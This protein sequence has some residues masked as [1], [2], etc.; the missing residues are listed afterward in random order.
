MPNPVGAGLPTE[1]PTPP[2]A[3]EPNQA[4]RP[5]GEGL[6]QHKEGYR[7]GAEE[8][9]RAANAGRV[10]RRPMPRGALA[11]ADP[12]GNRP[13]N[14][15]AAGGSFAGLKFDPRDSFMPP[16]PVFAM[17][18]RFI[19]QA[20]NDDFTVLDLRGRN[21]MRLPDGERSIDF[22]DFFG[23]IPDTEDV[24]WFDPRA[25]YDAETDRFWLA[26]VGG[27]FFA[28]DESWLGL[29]VSVTD[30]PTGAWMVYGSRLD[31]D[32]NTQTARWGDFPD[33]GLRGDF[34]VATANQFDF[35][36]PYE[37]RGAKVR[38]F[39]KAQLLGGGPADYADFVG[40]TEQ[41]NSTA[42]TLRVAKLRGANSALYLINGKYDAG[43]SVEVWTLGGTPAAPNLSSRTIT[44]LIPY[45]IPPS[46]RQPIAR[47]SFDEFSVDTGD[48]RI[49]TAVADN[50]R[51]WAAHHS[52][53]QWPNS[54]AIET[55][56]HWME[57]DPVAGTVVQQGMYGA[58]GFDYYYP[59]LD[60][61]TGSRP[62][63]A[64][65]FTRSGPREYPGAR[66]TSRNLTTP[67]GRLKPS[68][69]LRGGSGNY[70]PSLFTGEFVRWGDYLGADRDPN[71]PSRAL[72]LGQYS[73]TKAARDGRAWAT[74]FA[75][76]TP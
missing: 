60:T 68:R 9:K 76:L 61:T 74:R 21:V 54:S 52:S 48:A 17:G 24:A 64:M 34:V 26:C 35:A 8:A 66:M 40:L 6:P 19:L 33:I 41:D 62:G 65:V 58:R 29:A 72:L 43:T 71:R 73:N 14:N 36:F 5:I 28:N 45:S 4:A 16:D 23:Q 31:F 32:G 47:Q 10:V 25:L 59:C 30:D 49:L 15:K 13:A 56:I 11:Q 55:A 18:R 46:A 51:I 53:F 57:L 50:D 1:P 38:V 22:N 2:R 7:R 70:T 75:F 63:V 67:A 27:D 39:S 12:K 3:A 20:V 69:P 42:D 37:F 44:G